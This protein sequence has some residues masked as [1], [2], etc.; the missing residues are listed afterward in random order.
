MLGAVHGAF[1]LGGTIGPLIATAMVTSGG[2]GY[3][4]VTTYPP[5]P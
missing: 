1:G 3:L 4:V 2:G 5:C